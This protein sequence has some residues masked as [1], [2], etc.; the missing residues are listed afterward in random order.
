M[1]EEN[2]VRTE[3]AIVNNDFAAYKAAK[4]RR[5]SQD[6]ISCLEE[7]INRLETCIKRLEQTIKEM[8]R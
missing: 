8:T 7:R 6:K 1:N 3:T 2:I 5:K 4:L